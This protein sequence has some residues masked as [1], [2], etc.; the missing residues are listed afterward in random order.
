M[1]EATAALQAVHRQQ[2]VW[3]RTKAAMLAN[4][5]RK[6]RQELAQAKS[7]A[8]ELEVAAVQQEVDG[9]QELLQQ[10]QDFQHTLD[11]VCQVVNSL[12]SFYNNCLALLCKPLQEAL[13]ADIIG[14]I[15]CRHLEAI[16]TVF[17]LIAV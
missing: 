14:N 9:L 15:A 5:S 3:L 17:V 11:Q 7:Q 10:Q 1:A 13:S 6:L 12:L 16:Q 4:F 2:S 8:A